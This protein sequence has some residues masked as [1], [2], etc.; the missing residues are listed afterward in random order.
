[1]AQSQMPTWLASQFLTGRPQYSSKLEALLF[2]ALK[3]Q[4]AK[5]LQQKNTG[6]HQL[7]SA[8]SGH[9]EPK[10]NVT[11]SP[12][13]DK[14]LP[15]F[16]SEK[17]REALLLCYR[18]LKRDYECRRQAM[19][20]RLAILE[21]SFGSDPPSGDQETEPARSE[22]L[23]PSTVTS[24]LE[25][26]SQTHSVRAPAPTV[27]T[28]IVST[29]VATGPASDRGGRL[30]DISRIEL[31]KWT[32]ERKPTLPSQGQSGRLKGKSSSPRKHENNRKRGN[33]DA[34]KKTSPRKKS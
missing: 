3:S 12:S 16:L 5:L 21:A 17:Q 24:L 27:T 8:Q 20:K 1:M 13:L 30:D 23:S 29:V 33:S 6:S 34:T 2:M 14:T 9:D 15:S 10:L 22:N 19:H 32:E 28:Q 7:E 31:P 25:H 11:S 4:Q 18:H 26:F